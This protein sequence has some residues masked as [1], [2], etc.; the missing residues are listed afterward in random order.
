M[1]WPYG[2][3]LV[4]LAVPRDEQARQ[5]DRAPDPVRKRAY[6]FCLPA[7]RPRLW[8]MGQHSS[9]PRIITHLIRLL[10]NLILGRLRSCTTV[11]PDLHSDVRARDVRLDLGALA[12]LRIRTRV[13]NASERFTRR[14]PLLRAPASWSASSNSSASTSV[15]WKLLVTSASRRFPAEYISPGQVRGVSRQRQLP[16]CS[17]ALCL[18]AQRSTGFWSTPIPRTPWLPPARIDRFGDR[19]QVVGL[20]GIDRQRLAGSF[21]FATFLRLP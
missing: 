2:K 4:P 17:A 3:P 16:S 20:S 13:I 11:L 12:G 21:E 7:R 9:S 8:G 10:G 19:N 1:R 6:R 14:P 18:S 5:A 15:R